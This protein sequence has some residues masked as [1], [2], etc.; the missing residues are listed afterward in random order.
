MKDKTLLRILAV[1]VAILVAAVVIIGVFAWSLF[2]AP[3]PQ[4]VRPADVTLT[5][6]TDKT[7]YG[8]GDI[9][10]FTALL[11]N[12]ASVPVTI[13]DGNSCGDSWGVLD[14]HDRPVW[15]DGGLEQSCFQVIQEE[16]LGPGE[17]RTYSGDWNQ[18]DYLGQPVPAYLPYKLVYYAGTLRIPSD[19]CPTI[20]AEVSIYIRGAG[21]S[22]GFDDLRFTVSTDKVVYAPGEEI[23]VVAN[24]TNIG[25]APVELAYPDT[26]GA[27]AEFRDG[28]G[29]L[30]NVTHWDQGC[31]DSLVPYT[32]APGQSIV[33]SWS[34]DQR[35]FAGQQVP[36]GQTYR[37]F[38]KMGYTVERERAVSVYSAWFLIHAGS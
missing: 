21:P 33:T 7:E 31:F 25:D 19:C 10:H 24:L 32:I 2:G 13:Q 34:W 3:S 38:A 20:Y 28:N 12:G 27:R 29:T 4:P 15:F 36:I 6:T 37:A 17:T 8:P 11:R 9:V 30:W 18:M 23:Q 26:C 5:L 35:D 1:S 22:G 14:L 16:V